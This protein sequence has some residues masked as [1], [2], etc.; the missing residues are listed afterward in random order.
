MVYAKVDDDDMSLEYNAN[1]KLWQ[2]KP[3]AYKRSASRWAS[4][5]VPAKCLPQDGPVGLWKV[6]DGENLVNQ[7]AITIKQE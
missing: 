4:C 1:V 2:L 7:P 6:F 3:T 5:T